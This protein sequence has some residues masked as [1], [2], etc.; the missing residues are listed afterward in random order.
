MS[1]SE[2]GI[3][4]SEELATTV[5]RGLVTGNENHEDYC[6]RFL[7]KGLASRLG[8]DNTT[9]SSPEEA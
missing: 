3:F 4:V 1:N 9:T 5:Y 7:R 6:S 2:R 8:I